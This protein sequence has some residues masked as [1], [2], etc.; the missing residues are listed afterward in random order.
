VDTVDA[1]DS[2][3]LGKLYSKEV[4]DQTDHQE[5]K[6]ESA[7]RRRNEYLLSMLGRKSAEQFDDFLKALEETGQKHVVCKLTGGK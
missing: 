6:A 7:S 2:G 5:L 1:V 3:L 4:I